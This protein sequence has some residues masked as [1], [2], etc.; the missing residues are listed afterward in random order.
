MDQFLALF[1]TRAAGFGLS[2]TLLFA[3]FG[4]VRG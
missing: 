2:A 1:L 4:P 3:A